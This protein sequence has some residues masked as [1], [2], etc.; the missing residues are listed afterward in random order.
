MTVVRDEFRHGPLGVYDF[1]RDDELEIEIDHGYDTTSI[2]IDRATA[3][4]LRDWLN[5]KVTG[6]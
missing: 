3:I 2:Y 1:D 4:K 5:E 6:L